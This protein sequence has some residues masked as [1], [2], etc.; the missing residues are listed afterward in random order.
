MAEVSTIANS[1]GKTNLLYCRVFH[2]GDHIAL[3]VDLHPAKATATAPK[4]TTAAPK[5][6]GKGALSNAA[7]VEQMFGSEL[8]RIAANQQYVKSAAIEAAKVVGK[9]DAE[10]FIAHIEDSFMIAGKRMTKDEV[11]SKI[12][13]NG[14][15][16]T[17]K[18]EP[19]QGTDKTPYG[20]GW[21]L[22]SV[23]KADVFGI[24][25]GSGYG[26]AWV[27]SCKAQPNGNYSVQSVQQVNLGGP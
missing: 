1:Y 18:I 26:V 20:V 16:A 5:A 12:R 7:E 24:T 8:D 22:T 3:S 10:G 21:R 13:A 6:P 2:S 19:L 27:L 25:S 9:N 15:Q 17:L 23:S 14:L 4:A 11:A